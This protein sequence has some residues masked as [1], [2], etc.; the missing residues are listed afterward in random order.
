MA[1]AEEV[2]AA[3]AATVEAEEV[4]ADME[5]VAVVGGAGEFGA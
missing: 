3:M 5:V 1:A 2:A 4:V